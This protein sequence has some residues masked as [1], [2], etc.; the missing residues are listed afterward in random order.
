MLNISLP[1]K[2]F[3]LPNALDGGRHNP[4]QL[5]QSLWAD[6]S[7]GIFVLDVLALGQ[8][9]RFAAFNPAIARTSPIPVDHLLGKTLDEALP[10]AQAQAHGDRYR[11]CVRSR[12]SF[13]FEEHF[14]HAGR[15]T[16]WLL[17]VNPLVD[18]QHQVEQL[19][20]TVLDISDRIHLEANQ[21]QVERALAESEAKFRHLVETANDVIGVW[22]LDGIITYLSPSFQALS[23]HAPADYIGTSFTPLVHPDDLAFCLAA[24][25]QVAATGEPRSGLEFRH[26]HQ[27]GHWLWISINLSPIKSTTGRV[28]ALQGILRDVSDRKQWEAELRQ[29]QQLLQQILDTLPLLVFWKDRDSVFQGCNQLALP[30]CGL[31]SRQELVGKTDY[32]LPWTQAEADGYR[33]DDR[34]VMQSGQ[35]ELNIVETRQQTDGR[36]VILNTNKV[37]LRDPE[38][39]VTGI[40]V[41]I[42]DISDRQ[43]YENALR[44]I[45]E[46]TA[47][48]TGEDFFQ[49]CVRSLAEIFQVQYAFITDLADKTGDKCRILALW[50]GAGFVEPYEFDLAGTPCAQVFQAGW[51]I[52]PTAIQ[53]R[54]PEASALATL[55]AESYLGVVIVDAQGNAIGNLGLIDTKPLA[56]DLTTA[57]SILQLFA[58]RVGA[59]M[60]RQAAAVELVDSEAYYRTLIAESSI[61]LLLCRMDGQFVYANAVC[62]QIVGRTV[63]EM[64]TLSYWELTPE[65]YRE[66]EQLQ[67]QSLRTTGRY[68]S[69]EKEYIHRQ[70]HLV[71]VR[72][73]GVV[74]ERN[75]EQFIWSSIEDISDRKA[76]ETAL[77]DY[78]DRQTLLNQL[79]NQIRNSLDLETVIA[80]T[81]DSIRELLDIDKCAFAWYELDTN[82]PTWHVIQEV[83]RDEI[84]SALGYY[85]ATLVGVPETILRDQE[86]LQIDDANQFE[87]PVHR[88]FLETICCQ[89]EILLPIHTHAQRFGI[90]I[91][92]QHNQVRPWTEGEKALLKAASDQLAIAI[93]QAELYAE[94]RVKSQK[95]QQTLKE[96]QRTQ[97]QMVQSEKMSSLGQLVAGIAHEIN[98][99]VNFI[100]GNVGHVEEYTRDLLALMAL[101]LQVYPQPNAAIADKMD[102][103]DL[104]FLREDLPKLL[105]SMR[106]G[107]ERIREIVKSLRSF[108]RLDEA[109]VKSVNIH[110]GIDS[111]LMILQNRIKAKSDRSEIQ[112]IKHYGEVPAIECFAGQLNQVF[113]NILA[114]AIDALEDKLRHETSPTVPPTITIT[115]AIQGDRVVIRFADNGVGIPAAIQAQIFDPFFTTKPVG[116]GTGMGMSISYQ[117]VTEKHGGQLACHSLP[118]QGSEFVI[119]I[120]LQQ[121]HRVDLA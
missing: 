6:V 113:M 23:G 66:Q 75:G 110:E 28:I 60:A 35:A 103:V 36:Q 7:Y 21:A 55:G 24:N 19:L 101:F 90:I 59:E 77:Q 43:K 22:G 44:F 96:L 117:I 53:T 5:L 46:G 70:G 91:C 109:D 80:N 15:E 108:S 57:K 98:N 79:A 8:E 39:N 12:Q 54:F 18:A 29:S 27:Q 112:I 64:A 37:P 106:M 11:E 52:F 51:G 17:T 81:L 119:Q 72:L 3:S 84:P 33:R 94:S 88:A 42:E 48:K 97:A 68:S 62:A 65:K 9:F 95:L 4:W 118:G 92:L 56:D 105:G 26:R 2:T 58:T 89:S 85:P 34:R 40:L 100:H 104:D 83:K 78:A 67:L 86:I 102:E 25:Q 71:P 1:A 61:G 63:E 87:E 30:A 14:I 13:A 31:S 111:T 45:V 69:Y 50:T 115:T 73:S 10:A 16:A 114:N 107:T 47:S 76:A 82:S 49:A 38:G 121:G 99:P 120:P 116:K 93:D 41:T 32:D 20:V 74:V